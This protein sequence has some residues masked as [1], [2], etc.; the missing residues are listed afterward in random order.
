MKRIQGFTLR[1]RIRDLGDGI[2]ITFAD[3]GAGIPRLRLQKIRELLNSENDE[4]HIGIY[5]LNRRLVLTFG[6]DY[7][8]HIASSENMGTRIRIR[9]PKLP[10]ETGYR[11][12]TKL[13]N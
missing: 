7:S 10:L 5:N 13:A 6:E 4:R 2:Q 11:I 1:I 8:L 3:N 12:S 9:L